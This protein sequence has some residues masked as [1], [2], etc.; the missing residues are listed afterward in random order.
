M[1]PSS[2]RELKNRSANLQD[3]VYVRKRQNL[4]IHVKLEILAALERGVS[5][6][7]VLVNLPYFL[8]LQICCGML[9]STK[10]MSIGPDKDL[11]LQITCLVF[12]GETR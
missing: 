6:C 2:F 9:S 7:T 1:K 5:L 8:E 11:E 10:V 3:T 12:T 4:S